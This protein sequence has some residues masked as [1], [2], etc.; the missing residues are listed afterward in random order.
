MS[1]EGEACM[2]RTTGSV[3]QAASKLTEFTS[4]LQPA[5]ASA[6]PAR[7]PPRRGTPAGRFAEHAEDDVASAGGRPTRRS[8]GC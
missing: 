4:S 6:P 7:R 5:V 2:T 3:T 1:P 8:A